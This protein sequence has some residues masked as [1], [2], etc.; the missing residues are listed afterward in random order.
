MA[1]LFGLVSARTS[2]QAHSPDENSL[3]S[4]CVFSLTLRADLEDIRKAR[5]GRA[6]L[7]SRLTLAPYS[8]ADPLNF[9][10]IFWSALA[11]RQKWGVATCVPTESGS[12]TCRFVLPLSFRH[13]FKTVTLFRTPVCSLTRGTSISIL[14]N[15]KLEERFVFET[16]FP[17]L[18]RMT[19]IPELSFARFVHHSERPKG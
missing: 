6:S 15:V 9:R 10:Q 11:R 1:Q 14:F 16:D 5:T 18:S 3:L 8:H 12:S 13:F 17:W 4:L 7:T 19:T 2:H